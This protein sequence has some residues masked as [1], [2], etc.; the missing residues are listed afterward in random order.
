MLIYVDE[1]NIEAQRDDEFAVKFSDVTEF[2]LL[3]TS[4]LWA[5]RK[6]KTIR[7]KKRK[8]SSQ[9]KEKK[10]QKEK[11]Q[12]EAK[13]LFTT[14]QSPTKSLVFAAVVGVVL[15]I[16]GLALQN[17]IIS[18]VAA[19]FVSLCIVGLIVTVPRM[20]TKKDNI[21]YPP[22]QTIWSRGQY[23]YADHVGDDT[24]QYLQVTTEAHVESL[25][26]LRGKR[27]IMW[28]RTGSSTPND[29]DVFVRDALPYLSGPT[30]LVT[31]DGDLSIPAELKPGVV[32][33]ILDSENIVS[34]YTQNLMLGH[35]QNQANV[36]KLKAIPIGLDLHSIK[37]K[38]PNEV[39]SVYQN[40]KATHFVPWDKR[41][42][43][44]FSDVHLTGSRCGTR[45]RWHKVLGNRPDLSESKRIEKLSRRI[46]REE[47]WARYSSV[48]FVVI[49]PGN[50]IDTHRA[51]EAMFFG[52]VLVT[53]ESSP[54]KA[55]FQKMNMHVCYCR[56]DF[57]DIL[58]VTKNYERPENDKLRYFNGQ[59]WRQEMDQLL[60]GGK[61]NA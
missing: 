61:K 53:N 10:P 19:S 28:L 51:Y 37:G 29:L 17:T 39:W 24:V 58:E 46:S 23:G 31:T 47:L 48:Q 9:K 6:H 26:N 54:L 20:F 13:I 1:E 49:L 11:E 5:G 12:Q 55:L 7:T 3:A 38:T 27:G 15:L 45:E 41:A 30:V 4:Q 60:Y 36:Q 21:P 22:P 43:I 40:T 8:R 50:G 35:A 52:A 59:E 33:A 34:W 14:T 2:T 42:P 44:I 16:C 25:T 57:S 56:D 32:S 18:A